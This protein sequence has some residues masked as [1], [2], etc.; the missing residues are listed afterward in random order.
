MR[1]SV[2]YDLGS[3]FCENNDKSP[4]AYTAELVFCYSLFEGEDSL[5]LTRIVHLWI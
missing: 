1:F 5:V 4:G 3:E 2:I